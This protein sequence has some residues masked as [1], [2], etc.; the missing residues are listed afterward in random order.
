MSL[1]QKTPQKIFHPLKPEAGLLQGDSVEFTTGSCNGDI[2]KLVGGLG[3]TRKP[4]KQTAEVKPCDR[5]K[6]RQ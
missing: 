4:K 6:K 2:P 1:I 5:L 3:H